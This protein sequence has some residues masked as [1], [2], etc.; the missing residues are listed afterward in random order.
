M[1]VVLFIAIQA[2]T[3]RPLQDEVIEILSVVHVYT[4]EHNID[5]TIIMTAGSGMQLYV[6]RHVTRNSQLH[7]GQSRLVQAHCGDIVSHP[8]PCALF[9]TCHLTVCRGECRYMRILIILLHACGQ[10]IIIINSYYFTTA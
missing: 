7:Y 3:W 6:C 1:P 4:P 9:Y 8:S 10:D 2:A 5:R